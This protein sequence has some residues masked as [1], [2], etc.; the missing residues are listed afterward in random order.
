METAGKSFCDEK[1]NTFFLNLSV[2]KVTVAFMDFELPDTTKKNLQIFFPI[3]CTQTRKICL[4]IPEA[5][6]YHT[7]TM[8]KKQV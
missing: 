7:Y 2:V 1:I 4:K 6:L 8:S 5:F 3:I